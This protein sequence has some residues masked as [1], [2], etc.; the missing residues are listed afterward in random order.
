MKKVLTTSAKYTQYFFACLLGV[1]LVLSVLFRGFYKDQWYITIGVMLVSPI[2]M[3]LYVKYH[4]LFA[5]ISDKK[6]LNI[7][8]F[9]SVFV[10]IFQI[11]SSFC[12]S[13]D[14]PKPADLNLIDY[15]AR[16]LAENFDPD[17]LK[18]AKL[19]SDA[20]KQTEFNQDIW[21]YFQVYPYQT[22]VLLLLTFLYKI[23]ISPIYF[24]IF[25]LYISYIFTYLTAKKIYSDNFRPLAVAILAAIFP[26]FYTFTPI[27]YTDTMSMPFTVMC[28]YFVTCGIKS[29]DRKKSVVWFIL[30]G[31]VTVLG[32]FI[33]ASVGIILPAVLIFLLFTKISFK[34][35]IALGSG[36]CGV[37]VCMS[38][39]LNLLIAGT[40]IYTQESRKEYEFPKTHWV[41]MGI[42]SYGG[43]FSSDFDKTYYAGDF[44]EKQRVNLEEIGTRVD[45]YNVFSFAYHVLIKVSRTWGDGAY[46]INNG[47]LD[48][49]FVRGKVFN[50]YANILN[51]CLMA[52][53]VLGLFRG[54]R[55]G[56]FGILFLCR[57]ILCGLMLFLVVW[58]TRSRYL[59]NFIPLVLLLSVAT[60]PVSPTNH[61][62][63]TTTRP[64][65]H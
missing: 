36:F 12:L 15:S 2:L 1:S 58:E 3:L 32:Y 52:S 55:R 53:V 38:I 64:R 45:G 42:K 33:K 35:K 11:I 27:Y 46:F 25:C 16:L 8:L 63:Q 60:E 51:V 56:D 10:I 21:K 17:V 43:Y 18:G 30:A 40:G 37:F 4:K 22:S 59:I 49:D 31:F 6:S 50:V 54:A 14:S 47:Y 39:V 24:N 20:Y 57:I 7:F 28:I 5:N 61:A 29:D 41:M 9:L 19:P 34:R 26:V 44:E 65:V 23:G 62:T 13:T 48:S